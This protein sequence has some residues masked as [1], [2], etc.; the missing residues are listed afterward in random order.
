MYKIPCKDCDQ[1]YIGQTGRSLSCR[2]KEHKRAVEKGDGLISAVAEHVWEK[3]HSMDWTGVDILDSS[4]KL[5]NRCMLESWHIRSHDNT[6]NREVGCLPDRYLGSCMLSLVLYTCFI[7][8]VF[9]TVFITF[10][11]TYYYIFMARRAIPMI[12]FHGVESIYICVHLRE[13]AL[14]T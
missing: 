3:H 6:L 2:L 12:A 8:L 13:Y 10:I 9:F 11:A 1:C 7:T 14:H 5:Y 4:S